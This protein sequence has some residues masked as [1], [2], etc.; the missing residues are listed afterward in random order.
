MAT[1]EEF[2]AHLLRLKDPKILPED[3]L[4]RWGNETDHGAGAKNIYKSLREKVLPKI[5]PVLKK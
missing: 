4:E 5:Q 2:K 1:V 3:P